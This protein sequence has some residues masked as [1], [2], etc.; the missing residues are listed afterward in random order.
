MAEYPTQPAF[1]VNPQGWDEHLLQHPVLKF[2]HAH[3]KLFDAQRYEECGPFY[4]PVFTYVKSNGQKLTGEQGIAALHSDYAIFAGHYHEPA[5]VVVSESEDGGGYRLF[6][7]AR[8]FVNLPPGG[9]GNGN[10]GEGRRWDCEAQGAFIFDFVKD[11]AGPLGFRC[12]YFQILADPTP[13]LA[14]AMERDA[15]GGGG[16]GGSGAGVGV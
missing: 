3:E 2:I 4:G 10:N 14:V 6:G 9:G 16:G 1:I 8:M 12:K 13:I 15:A 5:Y 11:P 7:Y